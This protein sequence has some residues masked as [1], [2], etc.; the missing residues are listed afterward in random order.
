MT[1]RPK[2]KR[3]MIKN[4]GAEFAVRWKQTGEIFLARWE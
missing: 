4:K 2:R 1:T 3:K